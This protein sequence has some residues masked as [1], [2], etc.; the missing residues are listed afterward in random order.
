MHV[1]RVRLARQAV[2]DQYVYTLIERRHFVAQGTEI[3]SISDGIVTFFEAQAER[4]RA[5]MRLIDKVHSGVAEVQFLAKFAR[6]ND[7]PIEI[8]LLERVGETKL[9]FIEH[10]AAGVEWYWTAERL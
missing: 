4:C 10:I 9:E 5:A 7:W 2:G 3:D 6:L 8:R 1:R